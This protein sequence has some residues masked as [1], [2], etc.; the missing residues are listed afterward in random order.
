MATINLLLVVAFFCLR[1]ARNLR[2]AAS[3]ATGSKVVAAQS[4]TNEQHEL[5][6][7]TR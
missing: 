1:A 7:S 2:S 3:T 5:R 4:V 6:P